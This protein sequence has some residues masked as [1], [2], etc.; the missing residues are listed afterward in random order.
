M[1]W[2]KPK[3]FH[4]AVVCDMTVGYLTGVSDMPVG[5]LTVMSDMA[6]GYPP[7]TY[8]AGGGGSSSLAVARRVFTRNSVGRVRFIQ[9]LIT[10]K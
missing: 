2:D 8:T 7:E 3:T 10:S 9:P 4:I 6:A 1:P 5:Y